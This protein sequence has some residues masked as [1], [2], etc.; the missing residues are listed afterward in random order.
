[1]ITIGD[2]QYRNLEEQVEK[3][4]NDIL[5]MLEEEGVLNEFGIRIVGEADAS[6]DLPNPTTYKGEF[7][8]AYAV[9]TQTPYTIYI[10]TRANGTHLTNYWFN[11]G[12]FPLAGPTGATGATGPTGPTGLIALEYVGD[13]TS[14]TVPIIGQTFGTSD[15]NFNRTPVIGDYFFQAVRGVVNASVIGRTWFCS[16]EITSI[17]SG[18]YNYQVRSVAEITGATGAPGNNGATGP[19]GPMGPTGAQGPTGTPGSPFIIQGIVSAANQL[20][21]PST[22]DDNVAYL[23]G[24]AAPYDLYVQVHDED[25]WLNVGQVE[26]VVGPT[27]PQGVV[28]YD[29]TGQVTDRNGFVAGKNSS[30][31]DGAVSIG[32]NSSAPA[33]NSIALGSGTKSLSPSGVAIGSSSTASG[34]SSVS[35]GSTSVS[36][37]QY[38]VAIGAGANCGG[39]YSVQLGSGSNSNPYT[40]QFNNDNIYNSQTHTLTVQNAQVN[41]QNVQTELISG[42]NIKTINGESI[43]GSGDL[44][45][46]GGEGGI[47]PTGPAGP[48]GPTGPTGEQGP[49][50]PVG[51]IGPTGP[52]GEVGPTGPAG[53]VDTTNIYTKEEVDSG[54]IKNMPITSSDYERKRISLGGST[55]YGIF[56]T[57]S[58]TLKVTKDS[59]HRITIDGSRIFFQTASSPSRYTYLY[60]Q[61]GDT[62]STNIY[63]PPK[64]G[65]LALTSD[66][67][68][69]AAQYKYY[70]SAAFNG[71]IAAAVVETDIQ[72][73]EA[74]PTAAGV[75]NLL[76]TSKRI[77]WWEGGGGEGAVAYT[78]GESSITLLIIPTN[79]GAPLTRE[80]TSSNI[81][82]ITAVQDISEYTL[83]NAL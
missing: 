53:T 12:K 13:R 3:N 61:D 48:T 18:L 60:A 22:V 83:I 44:T 68:N 56:L 6:G 80:I 79:N 35:I 69:I 73:E 38:S 25:T 65:T 54:F 14:S 34:I 27:G 16:C 42:T 36:S 4:K 75:Y 52:Q 31:A 17:S 37:N 50:G 78:V 77:S 74:E 1:M 58:A 9:G 72:Y 70:I 59:D 63:L 39:P 30:A 51:G 47:G 45:I 33:T 49:I 66:I 28:D 82:S 32:Y 71:A 23:V 2:T 76:S 57:Q 24:T 8:D 41:G 64:A 81:A 62:T 21:A 19:T 5:Y 7:G 46:S 20:P 55:D 40:L 67:P 29:K 26:G 15:Q 10:F 11:I 43:L